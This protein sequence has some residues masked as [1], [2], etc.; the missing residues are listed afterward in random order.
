LEYNINRFFCVYRKGASDRRD[1]IFRSG[2]GAKAMGIKT[3]HGAKLLHQRSSAVYITRWD[4]K[5][6]EE[7]YAYAAELI[8]VF[9]EPGDVPRQIPEGTFDMSYVR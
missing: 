5:F 4:Q 7:Q 2:I 6:I 8:K 3:D 9:G 1:N